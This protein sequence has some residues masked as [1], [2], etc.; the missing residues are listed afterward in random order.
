[1]V[2]GIDFD[3][4]IVCYDRAFHRAACERGLIPQDLPSSK[5]RVRDYLRSIGHEDDWTELQGYVYGA[6]MDTATAFAGAAKCIRTLAEKGA[7]VY[8]ISHKTLYPYLG[9]RYNLHDSARRWLDTSGFLTEAGMGMHQVFFEP[10][11]EE[12]L[13]RIGALGCTHFVDDLPEIFSAEGFPKGTEG[14]LFDSGS[15]G[16]TKGMLTFTSWEEI[17][18]YFMGV[19]A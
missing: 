5:E 14:L 9:T 10:T 1:M 15:K 16:E 17:E 11:K 7:V 2:V 6:R 8:I 18:T 4:T 12:K 13:A 3:N 19:Y